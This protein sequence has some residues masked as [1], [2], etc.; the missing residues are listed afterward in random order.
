MTRLF[1]VP[2]HDHGAWQ[3]T[4]IVSVRFHYQVRKVRTMATSPKTIPASKGKARSKADWEAIERDYR[5]GILTLRQMASANG[6]TEG[7]IRKKAK[8]QE[9]A[10]NLQERIDQQI[11]A[12]LVRAEYAKDPKTEQQLVQEAVETTVSIVRSHRKQIG[13]QANLV[14]LLASQ[15]IEA[16]GNR[17]ELEEA[18]D[19]MT[20][21]DKDSRRRQRL[22]KSIE[23]PTHAS[24]AVNL[25]NAMKTLIGLERQAFN[26][27][28]E[29]TPEN[30]LDALIRQVSGS[31]LPV[32]HESPEE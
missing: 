17:D 27:K 2:T 20:K 8:E 24:T 3:Y 21:D 32:I 13:T 5:K 7:A 28:D 12:E 31:S 23:L 6:I 9:W 10:R 29:S 16:A 25:A 18:I 4:V 1:Y 26:I 11:Q 14:A 19:D 15:L 22:M 30:P